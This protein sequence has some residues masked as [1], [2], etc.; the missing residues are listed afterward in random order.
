MPVLVTEM[1][2]HLLNTRT[3]SSQI[4]KKIEV[5]VGHK[6]KFNA[7]YENVS[8]IIWGGKVMYT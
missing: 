8:R 3:I 1:L 5:D 2:N 7:K 4:S 6:I